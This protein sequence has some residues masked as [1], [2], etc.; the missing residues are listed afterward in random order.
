MSNIYTNT[1]LVNYAKTWLGYPTRYGWGCWGQPV[2][3]TII[4]QKAKQYPDHYDAARRAAL[5][6]LV[7]KAWLIDCVGLIKG[8]YWDCKPGGQH[9]GYNM[10]SDVS[11]DTMYSR[12][13]AKGPISTMPEIP[14][15]CV[16]MKGHIGIYIGNGY[17]IEST[18]GSFGD[19]VVQTRLKARQWLHW[20]ECPYITYGEVTKMPEDNKPST[21]AKESF[22]WAV[23][24]KICD[25][26]TPREILTKEQ[27]AYMIY[28]AMKGGK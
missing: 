6:K 19:G 23:K 25:A 17:V 4:A 2:S 28:Q 21:W 10:R 5:S 22:E 8:Y 11:A 16:Q 7:G 27:V 1:G 26:N 24:N 18:R 12:S 20:L 13:N 3:N 9:V 14:G 15:L